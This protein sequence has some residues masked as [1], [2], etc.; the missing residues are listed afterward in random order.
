MEENPEQNG[1]FDTIA[2]LFF[3]VVA[4]LGVVLTVLH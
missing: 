1:C 2:R 4:I 3:G